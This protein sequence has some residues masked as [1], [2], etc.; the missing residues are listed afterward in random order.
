MLREDT[1]NFVFEKLLVNNDSEIQFHLTEIKLHLSEIILHK[2]EIKC[3]ILRSFS[4]SLEL[5]CKCLKSE[6]KLFIIVQDLTLYRVTNLNQA[7][8]IKK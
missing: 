5:N 1:F 8:I 3:I 4:K 2:T 6:C 7:G